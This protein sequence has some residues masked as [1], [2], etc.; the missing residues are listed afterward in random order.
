[1]KLC[2]T[3]DIIFMLIVEY[4]LCVWKGV[5]LV[6]QQGDQVVYGMH[7]VCNINSIEVRT[8]NRKKVE[9]YVL[10][11]VGQSETRY[12]VPTNNQVAVAKM[13]PVLNKDEFEALLHSKEI[14]SQTWIEDENQR[15]QYC[16]TVLGSGDRAALISMIR[17][18]YRHR[19]EQ[20]ETGR[21]F[22]L[23]DENFLRDAERLLGSELSL[24]LGI[25][26]DEAKLY[27]L[28]ALKIADN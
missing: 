24:V 13:R 16:K 4:K 21:K 14:L 11:P 19:I 8:V 10:Q 20:A 18:L 1:M 3:G 25:S 9:Y 12:Y 15:K 23:S 2:V 6:F 5:V 27:I 26:L 22:H 17:L 7:G 28:Y